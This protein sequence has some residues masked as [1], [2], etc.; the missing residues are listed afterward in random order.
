MQ[1]LRR[2]PLKSSLLPKHAQP[3][4]LS[5]LKSHPGSD[6]MAS[7]EQSVFIS[8]ILSQP[9]P[10]HSDILTVPTLG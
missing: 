9:P 6:V 1:P 8:D 7:R 2:A 5:G 3:R 4:A 10:R